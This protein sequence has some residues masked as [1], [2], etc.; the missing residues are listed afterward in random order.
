[1]ATIILLSV[2]IKLFIIII[3][4][5]SAVLFDSSKATCYRVIQSDKPNAF[6]IIISIIFII[7]IV[8]DW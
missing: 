2:S 6:I 7:I 1:M 4:D 8:V 5:I 3:I